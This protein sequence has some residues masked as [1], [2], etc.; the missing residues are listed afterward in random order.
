MDPALL[1][2]A[3]DH[4][5]DAAVA[6]NLVGGLIPVALST[7]GRDQPWRQRRPSAW[8]RVHQNVIGMFP[9]QP[10]DPFVKRFDRLKKRP[11]KTCPSNHGGT[12]GSQDRLVLGRRDGRADL[13]QPFSNSFGIPAIVLDKETLDG[14]SSDSL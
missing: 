9:R 6:L 8:K 2:A 13:L 14:R 12:A 5:R 4:R 1:A 3:G 11:Q 10:I 7:E